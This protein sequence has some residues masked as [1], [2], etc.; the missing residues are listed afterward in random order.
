M[1]AGQAAEILPVADHPH[2]LVICLTPGQ[3]ALPNFSEPTVV[4]ISWVLLEYFKCPQDPLPGKGWGDLGRTG[5]TVVGEEQDRYAGS[6][7]ICLWP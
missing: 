7:L 1:G 6:R 2:A 5:V 3:G 4:G